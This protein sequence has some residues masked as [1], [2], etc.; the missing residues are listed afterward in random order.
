MSST[1]S[2]PTVAAGKSIVNTA[3]GD[4]KVF[5]DF[6]SKFIVSH[7]KTAAVICLVLGA[8]VGHFI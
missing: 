4:A 2:K 3:T 6:V 8:L 5:G 7:P 1:G